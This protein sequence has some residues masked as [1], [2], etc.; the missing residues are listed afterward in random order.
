[1]SVIGSVADEN[2]PDDKHNKVT[3]RFIHI[4]GRYLSSLAIQLL[5]IRTF[6]INIS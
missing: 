5:Y 1:M 4:A 2:P 6:I 3:H